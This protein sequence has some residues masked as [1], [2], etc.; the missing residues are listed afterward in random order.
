MVSLKDFLPDLLPYVAGCPEPVALRAIRMAARR[1]CYDTWAVTADSGVLMI[2][3][4]QVEL[5][6]S[7]AVD[8][9]L[10][11]IGLVQMELGGLKQTLV[12]RYGNGIKANDALTITL[13]STPSS[14]TPFR[15]VIAVAPNTVTES[16]PDEL[17][18]RWRDAIIG[19]AAASL[20]GVPATVYAS[21]DIVAGGA[22]TYLRG[23]G[24]ARIEAARLYGGQVVTKG[25]RFA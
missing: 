18:H 22:A 24:N 7:D 5:D 6:L 23:V 3:P 16:L 25:R 17:G 12:G 20:A 19:G 2:N 1:F 9:G 10:V 4:G 11:P 14:P 13:P 15:G 8:T 21:P